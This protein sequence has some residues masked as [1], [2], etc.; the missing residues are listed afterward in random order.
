MGIQDEPGVNAIEAE[1]L[2]AIKK[3]LPDVTGS[4]VFYPC[5]GD[6]Y[7]EPLNL[8]APFFSEFQFEDIWYDFTDSRPVLIGNDHFDLVS[9]QL[10][11]LPRSRPRQVLNSTG[12]EYREIDPATF[13]EIYSDNSRSRTLTVIRRRGF[14]QYGLASLE[15]ESVGLFI[16]RGDSGSS[17]EGGSGAFFLANKKKRH[18]P[19]SNLFDKV[20]RVLSPISF[21][22]TDGSNTSIHDLRK[23]YGVQDATSSLH[24]PGEAF[25]HFG[26][27]WTC[28]CRI[29]DSRHGQTYVWKVRKQA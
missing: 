22:V 7:Q 16:H 6:D 11:G 1:R 29:G 3:A 24:F 15:P 12:I 2:E 8:F 13:T 9:R 4:L 23:T 20:K 17:G 28:I 27:R 19:L 25:D 5:A 14:G 10:D 21:V 26:C 18:E